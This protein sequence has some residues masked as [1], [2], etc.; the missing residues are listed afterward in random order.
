M[1]FLIVIQYF[2]VIRHM[3]GVMS[4]FKLLF[5]ES[6]TTTFPN[7]IYSFII[8]TLVASTNDLRRFTWSFIHWSYEAVLSG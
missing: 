2:Q 8:Y 4:T 7:F 1:D 3:L 5:S 6:R